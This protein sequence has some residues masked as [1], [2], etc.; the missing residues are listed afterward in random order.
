MTDT[1]SNIE[2]GRLKY[3]ASRGNTEAKE[4][5]QADEAAVLKAAQDDT[6]NYWE[7]LQR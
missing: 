6:R 2:R 5:L 7:G 4:A 3:L 1:I